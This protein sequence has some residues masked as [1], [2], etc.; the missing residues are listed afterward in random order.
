M[1]VVREETLSE[2]NVVLYT[3]DDCPPC[4]AEKAWL[5]EKGIEFTERNIVQDTSAMEELQELGA[6]STPVTLIDGDMV[7]GFDPKRLDSLL[8]TGGKS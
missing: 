7:I 6:C 1:K 5:S 4:D 2:R 3:Q 8:K